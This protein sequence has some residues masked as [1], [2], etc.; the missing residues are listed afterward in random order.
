MVN[1]S[2]YGMLNMYDETKILGCLL[3]LHAGD[4]LGATIEFKKASPTQNTHTEIIGGGV[5]NWRPGQPTDD[6]D[7]ALCIMRSYM[8][9]KMFDPV[10]VMLNFQSWYM[11]EHHDTGMT[12]RTAIK[13][14]MDGAG[15]EECGVRNESAQGNGSLMRMAPMVALFNAKD[16]QIQQQ[17]R[18]TH[19]SSVCVR[20][21]MLFADALRM[22]LSGADKDAIISRMVDYEPSLLKALALP[23][24]Q[25]PNSGWVIHSFNA[26]MWALKNT[27]SF[28]EGV[29]AIANRGDDA[30][31]GAAITGALLGAYYGVDSIP[32]RWINTL[33]ACN[34]IKAIVRVK[35]NG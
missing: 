31:T 6:T 13:S 10:D 22:A 21:D 27:S 29:I 32:E 1:K 12:C 7:M 28:E 35:A 17:T 34:E 15:V 20:Y 3:G 26:S 14:F 24:E 8:K 16:A 11:G 23:W 30:D 19:C 2:I 9:K 5:F 4:C 25:L 33:E 18:L